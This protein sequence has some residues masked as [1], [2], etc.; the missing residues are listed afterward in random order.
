MLAESEPTR[1]HS[2]RPLQV[3]CFRVL[4]GST[5]RLLG[6]ASDLASPVERGHR[7]READAKEDVD[8]V[9]AGHIADRCVGVVVADRRRLTGERIGQRGAEGHQ[10]DGRDRARK[11]D[12]AAENG[13]EVADEAS[14]DAD[15]REGDNKANRAA[16]VICRRHQ[17]KKQLPR[18]GDDM[19]HVVHRARRP[20]LV[21]LL[22]VSHLEQRLAEL[23]GPRRGAELVVLELKLGELRDVVVQLLRVLVRDDGHDALGVF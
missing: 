5:A 9:A 3:L 14:D 4:R 10:R 21:L 19:H 23:L 17:R 13:S 22:V 8:A 20:V 18:D 11:A 16:Q 7:P 2:G 6:A 1:A 12:E 15:E